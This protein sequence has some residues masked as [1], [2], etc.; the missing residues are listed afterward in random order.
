MLWDADPACKPT[1]AGI[2]RTAKSAQVATQDDTPPRA[3]TITP[4]DRPNSRNVR[5]GRGWKPAP[6]QTLCRTFGY[7]SLESDYKVAL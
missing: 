1:T 5:F 4:G 3:I 2:A 7:S 6:A